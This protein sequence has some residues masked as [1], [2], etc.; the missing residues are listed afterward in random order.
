VVFSWTMLKSSIL[1]LISR[2]GVLF[3]NNPYILATLF[4]QVLLLVTIL[5]RAE[6]K[7]I[8]LMMFLVY[9][10]GIIILIRYCLILVPL[11][12]FQYNPIILLI[13]IISAA[14]PFTSNHINNS[15]SYGLLYRSRVVF[16]LGLLLYLVITAVVGIVD[17]SRGIMK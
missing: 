4:G 11:N 15:F 12:K 14:L 6:T 10:G 16:L 13:I 9:V 5:L 8:G 1:A 3:V 2:W 17:Y 7:F